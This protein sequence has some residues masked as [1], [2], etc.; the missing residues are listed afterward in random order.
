[1]KIVRSDI[2]TNYM[3]YPLVSQRTRREPSERYKR[4]V[5]A[6]GLR[7]VLTLIGVKRVIVNGANRFKPPPHENSR[8]IEYKTSDHQE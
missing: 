8:V 4:I 3:V 1:M 2:V 5:K 6:G 7:T